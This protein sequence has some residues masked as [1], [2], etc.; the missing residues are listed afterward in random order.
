MRPAWVNKKAESAGRAPF[1]LSL[2]NLVIYKVRAAYR[3]VLALSIGRPERTSVG[4]FRRVGTFR[5]TRAL[6][7]KR[8]RKQLQHVEH[9]P[10]HPRTQEAQLRLELRRSQIA[11]RP[12]TLCL[13]LQED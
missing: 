1:Q 3:V 9:R 4:Y 13:V 6:Q 10:P 8:Q 5:T 12:R 7:Q 11:E 2:L